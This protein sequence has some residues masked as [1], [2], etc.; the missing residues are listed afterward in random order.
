MIRK[1]TEDDVEFHIQISPEYIPIHGN[2][3]AIDDETDARVEADIR[4]EL[5]NGNEWA[6]CVVR[7]TARWADYEGHA[8]LG[9]CSYADEETFRHP[10]GYYPQLQAEALEELNSIVV[11]HANAVVLEKDPMVPRRGEE[12][13]ELGWPVGVGH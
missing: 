6:W 2:V 10:D 13:I 1:L 5:A 7:V 12:G 3:S 8:Y 11:K 4:R 9:G